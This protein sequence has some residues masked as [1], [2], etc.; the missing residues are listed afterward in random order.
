MSQQHSSQFARRDGISTCVVRRGARRQEIPQCSLTPAARSGVPQPL[1]AGEDAAVL[2]LSEAFVR[3]LASRWYKGQLGG[4]VSL[5]HMSRTRTQLRFAV[6]ALV[7]GLTI[8]L[9][10]FLPRAS[11]P[12]RAP[13]RTLA[14]AAMSPRAITVDVTA[15]PLCPF[16]YLGTTQLKH[17]VVK[18]NKEHAAHIDLQWKFHP[19][20]LNPS[21]PETPETRL[22]YMTRKFGDTSGSTDTLAK[23]YAAAGLKR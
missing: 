15:D 12:L 13:A 7:V 17:A 14:T 22:G 5:S 16:C 21:L 2:V 11:I 4:A 10:R 1:A 8:S 23:S 19:Y 3:Q 20:A 18:Y 6:A 9:F